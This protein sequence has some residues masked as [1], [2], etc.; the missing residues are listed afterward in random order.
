MKL[1]LFS[2]EMK[3]D[4]WK[5]LHKVNAICIPIN[6]WVRGGLN[7]ME[8]GLALE[9]KE[10][11]PGIDREIGHLI[12]TFE[13]KVEIVKAAYPENWKGGEIDKLTRIVTFPTKPKFVICNKFKSNVVKHMKN[14]YKEG[15]KVP[16]Y[17]SKSNL[18]LIK[19][20]S[21][22]LNTY[23]RYLKW[24]KVIVPKP[25]IGNGE[26]KWEKVKD[27]LI[28]SGLYNNPSVFFIE[29]K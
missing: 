1:C 28:Q 14:S 15:S 24:T 21:E 11:F 17:H 29:R 4:I 13:L 20:S 26:L 22:E 16:G 25:G 19:K 5:F 27:V 9:A 10:K 8:K 7:A 23:I 18:E 2:K 6:G 3:G 12:D